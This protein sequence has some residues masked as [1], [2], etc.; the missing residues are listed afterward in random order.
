MPDL[1]NAFLQWLLSQAEGIPPDLLREGADSLTLDRLVSTALGT[2]ESA[3]LRVLLDTP[4]DME[5]RS[6]AILIPGIMGSL[7][8]STKGIS[9]ILWLNPTLLMSGYLNLLDVAEDGE[10]DASPDVDIIPFGIEKLTYLH[11][12]QALARH[13]R[14]YE[15]PYDWRKSVVSSA[16][17]LHAALERWAV[18][19]PSRRFTIVCHSMGGIVSRAYLALYPQEAERRIERLIMVGVPLHGAP[20]SALTF[21]ESL[22]PYLLVSH[23]HAQNNL[24][25]FSASMPSV[26]QLL[27]AP[28]SLFAAS[29][30]YP[31]DWDI[32]DAS[33]WPLPGVRQEYL[34]SARDL[35]RLLAASDP[36]VEMANFAGCHKR[37]VI[38]VSRS[39]ESPSRAEPEYGETGEQSGDEQVPL[40]SARANNVTTYY[41]EESHNLLVSND[42]VLADIVSLLQG[43]TPGLPTVMPE[44]LST[45]ARIRSSPLAQQLSEIKARIES[46]T[47]TRVDI[48]RL[49]FWR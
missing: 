33:A 29:C 37:T 4:A 2:R 45:A 30:P 24:Q 11:L 28:E 6:P 10:S 14:L 25:Q 7:L 49:F 26:Y 1:S 23:L 12:I 22:H 19:D 34:D 21:S 35:H 18:A 46:G 31:Y 48:D 40:W 47:L 42:R 5:E 43:N 38:S 3:N 44:P 20:A 15:F 9:A 32:Y 13:T 16:H 8:A 17:Q 27:P 39:L 41:V 36:Q